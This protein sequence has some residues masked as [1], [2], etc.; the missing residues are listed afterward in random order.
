MYLHILCHVTKQLIQATQMAA[1]MLPTDRQDITF[2]DGVSITFRN[3]WRE[4]HALDSSARPQTCGGHYQFLRGTNW[5]TA[6]LKFLEC[7][8]CEI[9]PVDL[10]FFQLICVLLV[11]VNVLHRPLADLVGGPIGMV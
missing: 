5:N 6:S 9:Y 8:S 7:Q 1:G 11:D 4:Y 2:T 3:G 10:L